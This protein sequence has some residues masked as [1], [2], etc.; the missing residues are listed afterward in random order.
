M[1][2]VCIFS[3]Q[4]ICSGCL[5]SCFSS[6]MEFVLI[7]FCFDTSVSLNFL[8][9]FQLN[10][11]GL[12]CTIFL[13]DSHASSFTSLWHCHCHFLF[14]EIYDW[15]RSLFWFKLVLQ[16]GLRY[17]NK[18]FISKNVWD[19]ICS[20]GLNSILLKWSLHNWRYTVYVYLQLCK[21]GDLKEKPNISVSC[22]S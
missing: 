11:K 18:Q 5:P 17:W 20:N 12:A 2:E 6:C 13:S 3:F 7:F 9:C 15:E 22:Y 4:I 16:I 10:P 14:Y 8:P 21:D 19:V 1:L